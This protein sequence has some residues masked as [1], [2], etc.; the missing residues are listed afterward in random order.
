M[1]IFYILTIILMIILHILIYKKEDK[2]NILKWIT[3]NIVLCLAYNIFVCVVLSLIKIPITLISLSFINLFIIIIFCLKLYRDKKIQ[4]YYISKFDL[5]A[6]IIIVAITILVTVKFYG[7]PLNLKNSITDGAVHYFVAD[8]FYKSSKLLEKDLEV[9]DFWNLS[10]FMPGAYINTGLFFKVFAGIIDEIYFCKLYL[11]F[12]IFIWFLSGI[13]MYFLLSD[14]KKFK[15]KILP[16]V[17]S[18]LYMFAYPLNSLI[19]GFAYLS[20]ALDIILTILIVAKLETNSYYKSIL[21]FFLNF[22]LYFSY[23]YFMP[24]VYFAIFLQIIFITKKKKQKVLNKE[25]ILN[26]VYSLFMPGLFGLLFFQIIPFI[27]VNSNPITS[28]NAV[29]GIEGVIYS[30]LITNII[31]FLVLTIWNIIYKIKYKNTGIIEYASILSIL[32]VIIMF[33]GMKLNIVSN[34]YY[35]KIYYL[36]WIFMIAS[37]YDCIDRILQKTKIIKKVC[38][39]FIIIYVIGLVASIIINK[40]LIFFDIYTN[41]NEYIQNSK[42]LIYHEELD[43]INYYNENININ[44]KENS[45][46][47]FCLSTR[48]QG[49]TLWIYALTKN[50][51][52]YINTTYGEYAY[53]LDEFI[54]TDNHYAVIFKMDYLGNFEE[55]DKEIEKNNLKILFRNEMGIILE[56]N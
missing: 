17:F 12:N 27:T 32:F 26:I 48:E 51:Y 22:G 50:P 4:K 41:N 39:I 47:Y 19:S 25:C 1:G 43:I 6:T 37:T 9:F 11:I 14:N 35:Y 45:K 46:T 8:E 44:K 29:L 40:N 24:V 54:K 21:M 34:Y 7:I 33:I 23:Y 30:N 56:K 3:M 15:Q 16:V 42:S 55:I 20:L 2:Q 31:I 52:D 10:T 28:T 53:N 5:F 36:L 38:Y 49:R 13:L 18:L